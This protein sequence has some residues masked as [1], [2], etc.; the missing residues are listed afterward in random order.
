MSHAMW[1]QEYSRKHRLTS[2]LLMLWFFASTPMALIIQDNQVL[3]IEK[4]WYILATFPWLLKLEWLGHIF[5]KINY[6]L[7]LFSLKIS[8]WVIPVGC[9][10]QSVLSN[11][12]V[13]VLY[14]P[15]LTQ[16]KTKCLLWVF[17]LKANFSNIF[18]WIRNEQCGTDKLQAKGIHVTVI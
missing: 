18:P 9:K 13:L 11:T 17:I 10:G 8:V 3:V 4:Y 12:D 7:S 15:C 6:I 2:W 5:V 14:H 16:T 1:K